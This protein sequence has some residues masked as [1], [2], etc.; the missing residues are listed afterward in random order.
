MIE[1]ICGTKLLCTYGL[2]D[3]QSRY[4]DTFLYLH[5]DLDS[6]ICEVLF[7]VVSLITTILFYSTTFHFLLLLYNTKLTQPFSLPPP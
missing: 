3:L 1:V 4:S 5:G 2:E 7:I 6:W